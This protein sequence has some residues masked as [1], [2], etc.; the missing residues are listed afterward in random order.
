MDGGTSTERES[1]VV[2][3]LKTLAVQQEKDGGNDL[4]CGACRKFVDIFKLFQLCYLQRL[5]LN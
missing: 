2:A 4:V 5:M 3:S 1:S